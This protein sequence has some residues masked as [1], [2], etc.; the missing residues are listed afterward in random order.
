M[1]TVDPRLETREAG[2]Q[3]AQLRIAAR[4]GQ[5]LAEGIAGAGQSI[6]AAALGIGCSLRGLR[7]SAGCGQSVVQL[8]VDR[9]VAGRALLG[10]EEVATQLIAL[11]RSSI[12][13][14]GEAGGTGRHRGKVALHTFGTLG[15]SLGGSAYGSQVRLH[16]GIA[17]LRLR[18]HILGNT[19]RLVTCGVSLGALRLG[20]GR[21]LLLLVEL[22]QEF[23]L[24]RLLGLDARLHGSE[25][26]RLR[27]RRRG[28]GGLPDRWCEELDLGHHGLGELR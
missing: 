21:A 2:M 13:L 1:H 5:N 9:H 4:L 12:E 14:L 19:V 3:V 25:A 7:L 11:G 27:L 22:R 28:G 17:A 18:Q 20:F 8:G 10:S 16:L 23:A 26:F 6:G 15:V 24:P